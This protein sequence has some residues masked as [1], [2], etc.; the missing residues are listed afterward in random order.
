MRWLGYAQK[1][2]KSLRLPGDI[3]ARKKQQNVI[4]LAADIAELGEEP[5]NAPVFS[6]EGD[7]IAGRDR[8]AALL[9]NKAKRCW[10]RVAEADEQE[11]SDLEASENL[12]RRVDN[13]D[14]LIARRVHRLVEK[15][16]A[17]KGRIA[18]RR[19]VAA[20]RQDKA[21][22]R[23]TVARELG[24]TAKA[25][26]SA[27]ERH[28]RVAKDPTKNEAIPSVAGTLG[29]PS[30]HE[31]AEAA[32]GGEAAVLLPAGVGVPVSAAFL[33]R[34]DTAQAA[35]V[36]ADALLQQA[37]A[38][39]SALKDPALFP[40]ALYQRLRAEVH[41]AAHNVRQAKPRSVCPYCRD[42]EGADHRR[43]NCNGCGALGYLVEEQMAAVPLELLQP[44]AQP[45][46]QA[47]AIAEHARRELATRRKAAIS[48]L[49]GDGNPIVV[50]KE[51][52]PS[53]DLFDEP[54]EDTQ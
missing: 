20:M 32:R 35:I 43:A 42:P 19:G 18:S 33:L 12:H 1:S 45:V 48:I 27:E 6:T 10:I 53:A 36:K 51:D 9:I 24:T 40:S 7:I 13:R 2:I 28:A 38:A 23:K 21:E 41:A 52:P 39:L 11:R 3:A 30:T 14:E 29:T 22:A 47:S 46:T 34:F 15:I 31:S 37:Q 4:D 44:G 54:A 17:K 25:V 8:M 26:K 50:E 49:D 5:I 16:A